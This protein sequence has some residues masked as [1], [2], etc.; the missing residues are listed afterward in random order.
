MTL[1]LQFFNKSAL[2]RF[3]QNII[4]EMGERQDFVGVGNMDTSSESGDDLWGGS[5]D[6]LPIGPKAVKPYARR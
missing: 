2:G 5:L 3:H 4:T 6:I 1:L